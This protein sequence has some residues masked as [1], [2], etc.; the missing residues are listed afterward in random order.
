MPEGDWEKARGAGSRTVRH[1]PRKGNHVKPRSR[2]AAGWTAGRSREIEPLDVGP[3]CKGPSKQ[4]THE[5]GV[6]RR[7]DRRNL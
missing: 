2:D 5:G 1:D 4:V 6:G 3:P 7:G